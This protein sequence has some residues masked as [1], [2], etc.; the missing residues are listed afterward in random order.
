MVIKFSTDGA[1]FKDE[2]SSEMANDLW[3][4]EEVIRILKKIIRDIDF[5]Y[6]HGPIM[7]INGNKIGEWSL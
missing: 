5:D 4:R 7:D 6:N 2:S 3:T 1:A